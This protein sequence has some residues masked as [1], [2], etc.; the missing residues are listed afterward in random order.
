MKPGGHATASR[1]NQGRP[2]KPLRAPPL[3]N[4]SPQS[5]EDATRIRFSATR[6]AHLARRHN[7]TVYNL[8]GARTE[9]TP[10]RP[11]GRA[12]R[13]KTKR[14]RQAVVPIRSPATT[15]PVTMEGAGV[16]TESGTILLHPVPWPPREPD[17]VRTHGL[18]YNHGRHPQKEALDG[19]LSKYTAQ[20]AT[21]RGGNPHAVSPSEKSVLCS[22]TCW[23]T[24]C[25]GPT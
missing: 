25:T 14:T 15:Q 23:R 13:G 19:S 10:P 1:H 18:S 22:C 16:R 8:L 21:T 20:Q 2:F 9:K 6:G 7:A 3:R 11:S 24:H 4:L 17:Y 12:S 5:V